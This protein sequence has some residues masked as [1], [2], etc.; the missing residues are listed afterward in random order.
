M[1]DFKRFSALFRSLAALA[2]PAAVCG[3][4]I[5]GGESGGPA[6]AP[7]VLAVA[8][9]LPPVAALVSA[10]GGD[11]VACSALVREGADPHTFEP[12]PRDVAALDGAAVYFSGSME[13]ERV[14]RGKLAARNPKLKVVLLDDCGGEAEDGGGTSHGHR[15]EGHGDPHGWLSP[16][17]L[18]R[19]A[20]EVGAALSA[21]GVEGAAA[22]RDAFKARLAA[23]LE[24][25]RKRLA[26]AGVKAFGSV[27]PAFG[28]FAEAFGVE[29][30]ALEKDGKDPGPRH[31]AAARA[32]LAETGA[33]V[34]FVQNDGER[35]KAEAF[36]RGT[37]ATVAE[38]HP[39]AAD[40]V[41]T[42]EAAL[43]ALAPPGGRAEPD[44]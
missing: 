41:A 5:A 37:G 23:L 35:R 16:E 2:S 28:P 24:D 19:W 12:S 31:V 10:V 17:I 27:H 9:S 13:F 18:S 6:P 43:D 11:A 30:I 40:P 8:A 33:R 29:Q 4:S 7:A 36:A 42:I 1:S 14:L 26:D 21:A 38:I 44:R 25:G 32:R 39:A 15:G 20:D 22:R 34:V 3:A